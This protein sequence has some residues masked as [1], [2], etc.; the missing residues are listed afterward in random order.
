[1]SRGRPQGDYGQP[2]PDHWP[3]GHGSGDDDRWDV[4]ELYGSEGSDSGAP[5]VRDPGEDRSGERNTGRLGP[6]RRGKD[7]KSADR[8]QG[9]GA[10]GP[11]S[12]AE[13]PDEDYDWIK[14]LGEGRAGGPGG[15]AGSGSTVARPA[16]AGRPAAKPSAG[17]G[18]GP[19]K[20][21]SGRAGSGRAGSAQPRTGPGGS[22]PVADQGLPRRERPRQAESLPKPRGGVGGARRRRS[23]GQEDYVEPL[24]AAGEDGDP[25]TVW[26]VSPSA[27]AFPALGPVSV[28]EPWLDS[29][30]YARP[31]YPPDNAGTA[32]GRRRRGAPQ[33]ADQDPGVLPDRPDRVGRPER[34]AGRVRRVAHGG[35]AAS[36]PAE[37]RRHAA[38][39]L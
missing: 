4:D 36:S 29:A 34:E 16:T 23:A 1:M 28:D 31:L 2:Q 13:A 15:Q 19:D 37:H 11:G 26:P 25:R 22:A 9:R 20:P 38:A 10:S 6:S 17:G 39:R 3:G 8:N 33:D 21:G 14:Y 27:S 24:Y 35:V 12:G 30:E 7:R 32:P 18:S 5:P